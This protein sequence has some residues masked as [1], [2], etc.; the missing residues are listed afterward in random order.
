MTTI[1]RGVEIN[2]PDINNQTEMAQ[3]RAKFSNSEFSKYLKICQWESVVLKYVSQYKITHKSNLSFLDVGG[4][5]GEYKCFAEG[6]EN[7]NILEVDKSAKGSNLIY[8]NIC[9]C[10]DI[11]DNTY[12][13]VFSRDV[14]EHIKEPWLA[15]EECS[16]ITKPGGLNI[17]ITLFSWRWH[18]VPVD[19]FRYT[20]E[21]LSF[22]FERTNKIQTLFAGYDLVNRRHNTMGGKMKN[23]V[24]AVPLDEMGGFRENWRV[25]YAGKKND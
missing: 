20:H 7:Y 17:H 18:P 8:G 1:I 25:V 3:Y 6:F 21:G 16:R 23:K 24:D 2:G 13:I 19:M 4:R 22:L 14:F 9:R 10:N 15:A 11:K 12:D 5:N